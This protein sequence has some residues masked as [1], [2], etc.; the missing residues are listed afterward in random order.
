MTMYVDDLYNYPDCTLRYKVWC[1]MATDGPITELHAFAARLGLRRSWFQ[2]G[3]S[4]RFPHD[5]LT[6]NKRAQAFRLGA[7]PVPS[8]QLFCLC[9]S[10]SLSGGATDA[11]T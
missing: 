3:K 4:G 2:V 11:Q 9:S 5:D 7:R 6:P 10:P 8:I 1:H